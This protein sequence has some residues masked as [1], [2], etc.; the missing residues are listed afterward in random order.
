ME[1]RFIDDKRSQE[2]LNF[3]HQFPLKYSFNRKK[4]RL[5]IEDGANEPVL[6]F[7]LPITKIFNGLENSLLESEFENYVL[8]MI[9]A[10]I[11]SVGLFENYQNTDHK[12]F[13]AYMVRKKQGK[14][15]IKYLKTKGKSRAGSRVRLAETL[16]FFNEINERLNRYFT[17]HRID[18]IGIACSETLLPYI[19]TAK[20]IPPFEKKDPRIF[21][22][23]K[24]IQNPTFESLLETNSFLLQGEL[25]LSPKGLEIWNAFDQKDSL[26]SQPQDNDW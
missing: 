21:K 14:S 16:E 13:R 22:I 17:D 26:S 19:F 23:P 1:Q 4:H 25:L 20:T 3:L 18:R 7:R 10:G 2:F 6:H 15:Q 12:V 8:V 11:A 24:H 9:R 5:T